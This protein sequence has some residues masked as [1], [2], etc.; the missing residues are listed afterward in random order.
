[1]FFVSPHPDSSSWS[2]PLQ[3]SQIVYLE[4][5]ATRLYAEVVQVVEVRHLCWAR[6]LALVTDW[7]EIVSTL[8]PT[9]EEIDTELYDLRRGADLL[10]PTVLF[11]QALDTDVIPLLS[12]LSDLRPEAELEAREASVIRQRLNQFVRQMWQAQPDAFRDR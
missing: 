8:H 2:S 5:Q 10:L 9:V 4:H 1:M 6:P 3:P 7:L 11:H 12:R